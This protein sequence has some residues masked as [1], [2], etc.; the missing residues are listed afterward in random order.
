MG[1]NKN[2]RW[3]VLFKPD[4]EPRISGVFAAVFLVQDP[5]WR[6]EGPGLRVEGAGYWEDVK[7]GCGQEGAPIVTSV[8]HCLI[9]VTIFRKGTL[10][11]TSTFPY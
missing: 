4:S 3:R 5:G 1:K 7:R 2:S 6:V 10:V 9:N 8:S 11:P